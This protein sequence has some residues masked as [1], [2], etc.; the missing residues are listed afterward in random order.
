M[1]DQQTNT[2][3]MQNATAPNMQ[4]P[5][6]Q[7]IAPN[8]TAAPLSSKKDKNQQ[9]KNNKI[10]RIVVVFFFILI[11]GELGFVFL[12]HKSAFKQLFPS[13]PSLL[14]TQIPH[15]VSATSI[16][17][18][19]TALPTTTTKFGAAG[20]ACC[21]ITIDNVILNPSV[22]GD[23]PNNGLQYLEIDLSVTNTGNTAGAIPGS[24]YYQNAAGKVF[25]SAD[26]KGPGQ[27][28]N[29]NVTIPNKKSIYAVELIPGQIVKDVYL[30][31]QITPGDKGKLDW[32]RSVSNQKLY[33]L[34]QQK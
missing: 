13:I 22:N 26:V 19:T 7:N 10:L 29:K 33:P 8:T 27:Y 20:T 5:I 6:K 14:Q 32:Y 30:L 28:S 11:L 23:P 17:N 18:G 15:S 1:N 34:F 16:P 12:Y 2:T 3:Q 9:E 4:T 21:K 31:Y 25:S 24:F